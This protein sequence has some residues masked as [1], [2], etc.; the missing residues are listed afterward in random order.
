[1][2]Q[3]LRRSGQSIP[4]WS[5]Y[6]LENSNVKW[7][8]VSNIRDFEQLTHPFLASIWKQTLRIFSS[9][10]VDLKFGG[11]GWRIGCATHAEAW[12][13]SSNTLE[14]KIICIN[15]YYCKIA[16]HIETDQPIEWFSSRS[17]EWNRCWCGSRHGHHASIHSRGRISRILY[18]IIVKN[19]WVDT[20]SNTESPLHAIVRESGPSWSDVQS[21]TW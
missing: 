21:N 7:E 18:H 6:V 16:Q 19:W 2:Q 8:R 10:R 20:L 9:L 3:L 12:G 17:S 14:A 5:E 11:F 1:M 15:I 4:G 13:I